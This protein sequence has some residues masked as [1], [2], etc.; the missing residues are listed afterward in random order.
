MLLQITSATDANLAERK[1]FPKEKEDN[2]K[3]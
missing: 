3:E 2:S 1:L